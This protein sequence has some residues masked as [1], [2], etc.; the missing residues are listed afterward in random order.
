[1]G[2]PKK[3]DP[4]ITI[5]FW[6]YVEVREED[7]CWPWKRYI[8]PNGYGRINIGTNAKPG[9]S[10]IINAH[11]FA[12]QLT[13]GD[14]PNDKDVL[15]RCNNKPCCNPKHLYL[16]TDLENTRD[17]IE[18]GTQ[19]NPSKLTASQVIEIYHS[20]ESSRLAGIRFCVH[21][22]TIKEIRQGK[23]WR[24]VTCAGPS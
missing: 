2:R 3:T 1:M 17:R 14:I 5:R 20:T 12:Y 23:I 22:S 19:T 4:P 15:H 9:Q 18:A 13:F 10:R 21:P 6:S 8:D 11:R 24:N 7:E 16:G